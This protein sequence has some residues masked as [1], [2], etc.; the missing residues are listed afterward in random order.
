[1]SANTEAGSAKAKE[2]SGHYVP[3]RSPEER[4]R[5]NAEAVRLL[6]SWVEEGDEEEQRE[7]M[8]VLRE[9]LGKNRIASNRPLFP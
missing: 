7:T 4:A 2:T 8:R 1:M 5:R 6:R 3:R 9:A